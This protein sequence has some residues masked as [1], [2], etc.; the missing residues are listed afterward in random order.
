MSEL[1]SAS[2]I[3]AAIVFMGAMI[4]AMYTDLTQERI[5]NWTILAML[6]L[7]VPLASTAGVGFNEIT[8]AF[9]T[10]LVVF[11]AGFG[12]FAA[13]WLG[14]GDVKLAAAAA[15]WLGPGAV[16]PFVLWTAI[17]GTMI[18]LSIL[19]LRR[20]R[21]LDAGLDYQ[22]PDFLP[23]GPGIALAA[24]VIFPQSTWGLM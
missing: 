12:C 10:A 21:M 19:A 20:K 4:H 17:L 18:T 24:I 16:I 15:L 13:G 14:G 8:L 7:F 23:Y 6:A 2:T 9:G 11:M 22:R 5:H 1:G 3:T